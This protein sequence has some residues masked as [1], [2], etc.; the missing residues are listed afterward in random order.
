M[1]KSTKQF[2]ISSESTNRYGF[3]VIT[4]GIDLLQF[5]KNPIMLWMH[6]RS[7]S[8]S[9]NDVLPLGYWDDVH[10]SGTDLIG[11]PVFD[12]KDDFAKRIYEKVENGVVRMASAGLVPLEWSGQEYNAD[13]VPRLVRSI[14]DEAS[15]VDIGANNDSLSAVIL[16]EG[17][18]RKRMQLH[19][20]MFANGLS[21]LSLKKYL[22][23]ALKAH[24][25]DM[26][27]YAFM[28]GMGVKSYGSIK[29]FV[30][31]RKEG[32]VLLKATEG[33]TWDEMWNGDGLAVIKKYEPQRYRELFMS[34]FGRYPNN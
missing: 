33:K 30:E 32:Y 9:S 19:T 11:V 29:G 12:D 26:D 4:S 2:T 10:V 7:S 13:G 27:E 8:G 34:K 6:N 1:I 25:I 20:G 17:T 31:K 16:Y 15:I 23:E 14:L 3:K 5:R 21:E 28:L 22:A 24:R 18:G